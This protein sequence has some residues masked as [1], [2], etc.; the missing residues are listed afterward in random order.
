MEFW[1]VVVLFKSSASGLFSRM[2]ASFESLGKQFRPG[3]IVSAW[4][5][6]RAETAVWS[7]FARS[8]I[9]PWWL[10]KGCRKV[11]I[12]AARFAERSRRDGRMHWA[13]VSAGLVIRGLWDSGEE[14]KDS[15]AAAPRLWIVT[16][17]SSPS[18]EEA[19]GHERM[20]LLEAPLFSA[21]P[22]EI[23]TELAPPS[24]QLELF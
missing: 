4:V 6:Q 2:C 11:D 1:S 15:K 23:V 16:R 13:D 5:G 3:R 10:G 17:Q 8:E 7:G 20:P 22:I 12:P 21:A 24:P 18:E 19:F 9:L 14:A